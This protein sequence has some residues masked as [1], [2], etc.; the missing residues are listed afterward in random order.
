MAT[1]MEIPLSEKKLYTIAEIKAISNRGDNTIHKAIAE[2]KLEAVKHGRSTLIRPDAL[3]RWI[4][5]FPAYTPTQ[6]AANIRPR[7]PR[8]PVAEAQIDQAVA[9]ITRRTA[10]AT[11]KANVASCK[12]TMVAAE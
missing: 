5:S 9:A 8:A 7:K 2:G 6:L 3:Q 4:D 12:R 11:R 1:K 10:A